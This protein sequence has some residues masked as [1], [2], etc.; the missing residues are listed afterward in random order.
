MLYNIVHAN[1]KQ[2]MHIV[3]VIFISIRLFEGAYPVLPVHVRTPCLCY[4][5]ESASR[6][7]RQRTCFTRL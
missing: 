1:V 4:A 2:L 6:P 7:L 5:A 3:C